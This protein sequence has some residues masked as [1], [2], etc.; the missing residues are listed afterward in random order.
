M[1]EQTTDVK[2]LRGVKKKQRIYAL[3]ALGAF[4][5]LIG[6]VSLLAVSHKNS[7]SAERVA[8]IRITPKGFEPSTLTV[9]KGT[10]ITWTN[11]DNTLHQVAA[12]P[13]PT[14]KNLP[15]LKSEILNDAQQYTYVANKAGSFGYH[16]QLKPTVNGVIVIQK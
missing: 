13:Y 10:K 2:K 3:A 5:V 4:L 1:E 7:T 9:K 8:E 15:G 11:S 12:N 14:G 6:A 16:D